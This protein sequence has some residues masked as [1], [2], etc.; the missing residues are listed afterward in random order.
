M[1]DV[2]KDLPAAEVATAIPHASGTATTELAPAGN[3]EVVHSENAEKNTTQADPNVQG[4]I[5]I[6]EVAEPENGLKTSFDNVNPITDHNVQPPV[7]LIVEADDIS[8]AHRDPAAEAKATKINEEMAASD[9]TLSHPDGQTNDSY[10]A[11]SKK[12]TIVVPASEAGALMEQGYV[13]ED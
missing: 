7:E 9:V 6:S 12:G 13:I 2:K 10:K 3:A 1:A 8:R 11:G 5:A 4:K